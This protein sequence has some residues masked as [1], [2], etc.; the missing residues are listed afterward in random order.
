MN[1]ENMARLQKLQH[2]P[3]DYIEADDIA[4]LREQL[5][6]EAADADRLAGVAVG[7]QKRAEAAEATAER[8]RERA[9]RE[10]AKALHV[11]RGEFGQIC[12]YCGWETPPGGGAW[13]D[14]QAHIK[15]CPKHPLR[16]AEARIEALE[17]CMQ[18]LLLAIGE[19]RVSGF[20]GDPKRIASWQ[21]LLKVRDTADALLAPAPAEPTNEAEARR[22]WEKEYLSTP[23]APSGEKKP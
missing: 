5:E 13:E 18:R 8:E 16:A 21:E 9:E 12:S 4:W 22:R 2:T 20:V 6:A 23:S 19:Y 3:Q 11:V 10:E 1:A 14:L 15:T 7:W 17:G